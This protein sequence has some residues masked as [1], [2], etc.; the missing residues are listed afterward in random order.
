M[1]IYDI[2]GRKVNMIERKGASSGRLELLW[3]GKNFNGEELGSGVY[4]AK[5]ASSDDIDAMKV[6]LLKK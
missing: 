5:P 2:L 1:N 6:I 3:D 4:F